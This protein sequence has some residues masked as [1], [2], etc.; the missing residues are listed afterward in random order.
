MR[1][2][3][4]AFGGSFCTSEAF[5]T[6]L[7]EWIEDGWE[8]DEWLGKGF[9][10]A[11]HPEG[12]DYYT[13][14]GDYAEDLA[15]HRRK[16]QN[17]KAAADAS[18]LRFA[19][20]MQMFLES[21]ADPAISGEQLLSALDPHKGLPARYRGWG[22]G[23]LVAKLRF[24]LD[25]KVRVQFVSKY[26][27]EVKHPCMALIHCY[28]SSNGYLSVMSKK[29]AENA[30]VEIFVHLASDCGSDASRSIRAHLKLL[31]LEAFS[32]EF[33]VKSLYEA[34]QKAPGGFSEWEPTWNG[35][36]TAYLRRRQNKLCW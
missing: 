36:V 14:D 3:L 5:K 30:I 10:L 1:Q 13:L 7:R 4:E 15:D 25:N 12:G 22:I 23:L 19:D 27:W 26:A 2:D 8:F 17:N 32:D 20:Q 29:P 18:L 31:I 11:C 34:L 21:G 6:M 28:F 9:G 24:L 16:Q 35:A 33:C